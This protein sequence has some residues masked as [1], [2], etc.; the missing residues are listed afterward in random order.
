MRKK[1]LSIDV[2]EAARERMRWL[3]Q[4]YD[5]ILVGVSGGKD[6]TVCLQIAREVCA[7]KVAFFAMDYQLE[8][9]DTEDYL[10]RLFAKSTEERYLLRLPIT[11]QDYTS[12]ERRLWMPWEVEPENQPSYVL[13][14]SRA[15][16]HK[17]GAYGRATRQKFCEEFA[18]SHLGRTVVVLGI[19]CDESLN[20]L[21]VLTSSKRKNYAAANKWTK[22]SKLVDYAYPIYDWQVED[23]WHYVY[24]T[25]I[26]YN[27][28]YDKLFADR[29]ALR[30]M[31]TASPFHK[32]AVADLWRFQKY[33]PR[34]WEKMLKLK[35]ESLWAAQ[36]PEIFARKKARRR[37]G[38]ILDAI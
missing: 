17:R 4:N 2:L 36:H 31:R 3:D 10:E 16:W 7:N 27:R 8:H 35:P 34:N 33:S 30:N 19:R 15:P 38:G 28:L 20:R 5:H 29:V 13:T 23:V 18:R 26:D 12:G 6:S 24:E 37:N 9:D 11:A 22:T 1:Y 21:A 32:C 25:G 14:E